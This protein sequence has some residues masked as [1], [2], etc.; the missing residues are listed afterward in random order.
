[1]GKHRYQ[2]TFSGDLDETG[3]EAFEGFKIEPDGDNTLLMAD[4]DQAA[5]FGVLN[6]I[7]CLGL[8]LVELSQLADDTRI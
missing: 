8:E 6:G 2:I 1:M 7:R 4:M 3:R 5:L